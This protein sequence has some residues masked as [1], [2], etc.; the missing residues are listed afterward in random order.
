LTDVTK[1]RFMDANIL[2]RHVAGDHAS[3]SPA[4]RTLL[5]DIE[6]ARVSVWTTDLMIAEVVY[7]LGS[8]RSYH[9]S[10][11]QI[12]DGVLPLIALPGI[13]LP[14]KHVY[15]RAFELFVR[16]PID[17]PDAFHAALI[18]HRNE[19]ELYSF[20]QDFDRIAGLQRHESV[21]RPEDLP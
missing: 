10:R 21:A 17:F 7:V 20:D 15:D 11:Q 16:Y 6:Q 9:L 12:R 1:P 2:I 18:E 14:H 8:K 3:H 4:A 5:L 13:E 19:S